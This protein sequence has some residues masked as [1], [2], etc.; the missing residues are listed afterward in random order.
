MRISVYLPLVL[1]LL[2]VVPTGGLLRRADPRA[3][4]W[5]LSVIA[6]VLASCSTAALATLAMVGA[7]HVPVA[8]ELGQWSVPALGRADPTSWP[9]R[10]LAAVA[11][12]GVLL[13]AGAT[14]WRYVRARQLT[15][16]HRR[17]LRDQVTVVLDPTP[18]AYALPGRPGRI[19]V[20]SGMYS[21]LN[22]T[23]RVAL[24][25]HEQAHLRHRHHLFA[26]LVHFAVALNPFLRPL[27]TAVTYSLERWADE[28]AALVTGDRRATAHAIG[29]AALARAHSVR[30]RSTLALHLG[31]TIRG[32][33]GPVPQRV[34]ALL[35]PPQT[36]YRL[37]YAVGLAVI[38]GAGL[39]T[40]HA[41][42]D[43][44]ALLE[45]AEV[46]RAE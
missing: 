22:D 29:K 44:H 45:L 7:A 36:R 6:V 38:L 11:L 28:E 26:G 40:I 8:A 43:A 33:V 15:R 31:G 1:S 13:T 21:A 30:R 10:L 4:T 34:A 5:L 41:V 46:P 17:G 14:T 24:I 9:V 35:T 18:D 19:V 2:A 3:A 23:D 12:A 37:L 20:S 16:R 39:C 25:A 42:V 32:R 27:A